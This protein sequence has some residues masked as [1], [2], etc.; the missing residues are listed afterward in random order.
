MHE[1]TA[2]SQYWVAA[3]Q[4]IPS[5]GCP[6]DLDAKHILDDLLCVLVHLWM[7]QRHV[8]IAGDHIAKSTEPF[9]DSLHSNAIGKHVPDRH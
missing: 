7:H 4:G 3:D 5:D 6:E 9:L 1:S 2:V 8:V